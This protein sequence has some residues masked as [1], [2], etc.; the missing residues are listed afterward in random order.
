[1]GRKT[2]YARITSEELLRQVNPNN[3]NL[4]EGFL[5]YLRSIQRAQSTI[6][7]YS[8]DLD[9]VFVFILER[10]G[11]K[12]FIAVKKREWAQ[13]QNW[14]IDEHGNSAARV[15]RIKATLSSLSRYVTDILADDE[16]E[17]YGNF[18]NTIKAIENPVNEP[19]REKT[20]LTDEECKMVL[21][22]LLLRGKYE[23]A[24]FFALA[25]YSGRRKQE[26][27][28]FKVSFFD[29]ENLIYGCLY[30]S[31]TKIRSKGRGRNGKMVTAWVLKDFKPYLDMWLNYR[32]E[33]GLPGS[34]WVFPNPNNPDEPRDYLIANSWA[35][36]ISQILGKDFYAHS[37]RHAWC[38]A[39]LS[40]GIP[41]EVVQALQDWS[42]ISMVQIYDDRNVEDSFAE[43]F[44]AD[45]IKGAEQKFLSDL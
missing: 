43:Y 19:V 9:I 3:K 7:S 1:M 27:F 17:E 44:T 23:I 24:T 39:M 32:K 35:K 14:L 16:P 34:E 36:T 31:P 8:N 37:L 21:D 5:Y 41:A 2:Q 40:A 28:R 10:L 38:S 13:M 26:L 12:D 33:Q 42:N 6:D 11:N 18:R 45:G 25:R 15:R 20:I 22:E 29:E 4:K 30:K